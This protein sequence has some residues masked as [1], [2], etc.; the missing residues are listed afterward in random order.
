VIIGQRVLACALAAVLIAALP[1]GAASDKE[2]RAVHGT[3]Q[4][5]TTAD[6]QLTRVFGHIDL[7]DDAFAVTQAASNALLV[8]PDASEVGLGENTNVR[9]GAFNAA[10]DATPTIL[11]LQAGTLRFSVRHPA[12]QRA[13][14][15]FQTVTSQIAVRGTIGLY[16]TGPNGDVVT[17]LQCDSGDVVVTVGTQ[18]YTL[19]TGQ[20]LL[21][22]LAGIVTSATGAAAAQAFSGS[23]LSTDAA[24]RTAFAGSAG[25]GSAAA[26]S[27]PAATYPIAGAVFAAGA[28]AA[29]TSANSS[30]AATIAL[31]QVTPTPS[32]G[33]GNATLTG[34][35]RKH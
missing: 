4:F 26:A 16:G 2:L 11:T 32:V 35:P 20:T 23:G 9:V 14:Y 12:G 13:N 10:T 3:T 1:A 5:R 34:A 22:S 25:S 27:I 15:R 24:T 19:L 33:T 21:I 30:H 31:P 8:L 7:N 6:G 28:A 17:C 29:I 18:T